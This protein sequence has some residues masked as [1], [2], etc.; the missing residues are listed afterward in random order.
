MRKLA[1]NKLEVRGRFRKH[2]GDIQSLARSTEEVGL[3]H[4]V[5]I[6]K[7]GRLIA[8]ESRL[9][10]CKKLGWTSVPVTV[11]D[12]KEVIRGEVAE[13][14]ER[15]GF[16]PSEIDAIRRVLLPLERAAAKERQRLHGGTAPGRRKQSGQ[17]SQ[18]DGG[19]VRD[20][21]CSLRS[22]VGTVPIGNKRAYA[23]SVNHG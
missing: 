17:L 10:A 13:N 4:P 6:R 16:L 12:L 5:V 8:G 11:V 9:A 19:R 14:V 15:Q 1:I 23:L 20:Q 2:L 22:N 21:N 3:L 7:D 18:C